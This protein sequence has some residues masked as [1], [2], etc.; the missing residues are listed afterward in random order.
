[1]TSRTAEFAD[2]VEQA[3]D[4]ITAAAV[5]SAQP[6]PGKAAAEYLSACLS[7]EPR[8]AAWRDVLKLLRSGSKGHALAEVCSTPLELWLLR[9]TYLRP[10]ADPAAC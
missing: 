8:A 3:G 2:A 4:V 6:L 10:H 5:I 7:P 9:S 1:V